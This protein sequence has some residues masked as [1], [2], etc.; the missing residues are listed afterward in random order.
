MRRKRFPKGGITVNQG[1]SG[2]DTSKG[3]ADLFRAAGSAHHH[4]FIGTNGED[5]EWPD[6]YAQFLQAKLNAMLSVRWTRSEI[7]YLLLHAELERS[8]TRPEWTGFY[9]QVFLENRSRF[10]SL[11]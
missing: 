2:I 9:A 4:A 10:I 6:W 1:V 11:R 8:R 7:V 3:L 5:P